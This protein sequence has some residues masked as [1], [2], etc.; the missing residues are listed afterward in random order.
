MSITELLPLV[1]SLPHADKLKLM[2]F[3][4]M[5]FARRK[6]LP[7][8]CPKIG[9][10]IRCGA[11]S[12]WRKVRNAMWPSGMMRICTARRHEWDFRGYQWLVCHD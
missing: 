3:L 4:L 7:W 5:Q 2:Q 1:E 11:S 6:A 10:K 9:D 12:A 8:S